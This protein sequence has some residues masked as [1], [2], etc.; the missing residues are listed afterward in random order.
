MGQ[1][2]AVREDAES[3]QIDAK[4]GAWPFLHVQNVPE[5]GKV[6]FF[7]DANESGQII[8]EGVGLAGVAFNYKKA[9]RL[10]AWLGEILALEE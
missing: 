8:G 5:H 10:H 3:I 9:A 4:K 7:I 1:R 6:L 2:K